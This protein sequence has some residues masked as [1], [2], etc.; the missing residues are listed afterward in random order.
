MVAKLTPDQI[1]VLT[2]LFHTTKDEELLVKVEKLREYAFEEWLNWIS[3]TYRPTTLTEQ[4]IDRVLII[5]SKL[6][7]E[8]PKMEDIIRG[9]NLPVGR[10]RYIASSLKYTNNLEFVDKLLKELD[11]KLDAAEKNAAKS[12]EAEIMLTKSLWDQLELV[13]GELVATGTQLDWPKTLGAN[14]YTREYL[15]TKRTIDAVRAKLREI[16]K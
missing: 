14:P 15:L 7:D 1:K 11:A 13:V 3:G 16:S 10:A 8:V 2:R 9:F 5:Y 12:G 6:I 4:T